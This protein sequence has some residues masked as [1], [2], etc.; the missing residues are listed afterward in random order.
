[1]AHSSFG[2]QVKEL[3]ERPPQTGTI[4]VE[5]VDV[6]AAARRLGVPEGALEGRVAVITGGAHGIGGAATLELAALGAWPAVADQTPG[7]GALTRALTE[8]GGRG[9]YEPMDVSEEGQAETLAQRVLAELGRVDILVNFAT[10]APVGSL[11]ETD[12][13][14]WDRTIKANLR[15]A[16][17]ACK[18]F[19]PALLSQG[20]GTII[21][22]V[23]TEPVPFMSAYAASML[24]LLGM[25]QSLAGEAGPEGVNVIALSPGLVALPG[26]RGVAEKLPIRLGMER[27]DFLNMSMPERHAA[28][29]IGYLA[30]NPARFHGEMVDGYRLLEKAAA[31]RAARDYA[32]RHELYPVPEPMRTTARREEFAEGLRLLSRLR[33]MLERTKEQVDSFPRYLRPFARRAFTHGAGRSIAE[34]DAMLSHLETV[35]ERME[36]E[37]ASAEI[38]FRHLY[39]GVREALVLLSRHYHEAPD[40]F[41]WSSKKGKARRALAEEAARNEAEIGSLLELLDTIRR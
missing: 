9:L 16:F 19:L 39:P 23:S 40:R 3:K 24:A 29:A 33:L 28:E 41:P 36:G 32:R 7:E 10:V 38:G 5:E 27:E 15:G 12:A 4:P 8:H 37:E 17:L 2:E 34:W 25:T 18:A 21:N 1:M 26:L 11:L 6:E 14:E 13:A 22:I 20:G 31:T 35:L 30:A